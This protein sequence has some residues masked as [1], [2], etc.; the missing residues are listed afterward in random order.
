MRLN[1]YGGCT[2]MAMGTLSP[3]VFDSGVDLT[4]LGRWYWIHLGS[5]AK[6][7]RIVMAYQPSNSGRSVG[8]TVKDQ[9]SRYFWALGNAR[10]PRTIFYKQLVS[11]LIS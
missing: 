5:R 4:G 2:M 7:T 6:K 11:Q 10:S 8:T 1:Q 9:H 3:E